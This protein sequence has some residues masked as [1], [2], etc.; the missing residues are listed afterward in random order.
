MF[1][2]ERLVVDIVIMSM[3]YELIVIIFV[4]GFF[5]FYEYFYFSDNFLF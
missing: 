5:Y 2:C 3:F 4:N 1:C